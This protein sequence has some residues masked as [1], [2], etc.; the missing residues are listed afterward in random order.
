MVVIP[1]VGFAGVL[2]SPAHGVRGDGEDELGMSCSPLGIGG[3]GV[4]VQCREESGTEL[5]PIAG[6]ERDVVDRS[7]GQL[8]G[9][10]LGVIGIFALL[11]A[12]H[13]FVLM[14]LEGLHTGPCGVVR[15]DEFGRVL[16][17][18][19]GMGRIAPGLGDTDRESL[20]VLAVRFALGGTDDRLS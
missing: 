6:L 11:P 14:V 12:V 17:D 13:I 8:H 7:G 2:R 10:A 3:V 4:G 18:D 19:H 20:A 1:V 15:A 9:I 16:T 5:V